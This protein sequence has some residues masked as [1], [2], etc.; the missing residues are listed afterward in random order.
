MN[1]FLDVQINTVGYTFSDKKLTIDYQAITKLLMGEKIYGDAKLALREIVQN[2]IDA[3][4]IR[5]EM[6]QQN[7]KFGDEQ[8]NPTIKVIVNKT[9][10]TVMVKD[11]GYGMDMDIITNYFL[12]VGKSYYTSEAF[13]LKDFNYKPIGNF[14]IGFLACFMLSNEV[15]VRTRHFNSEN[16]ITIS[17]EKESEYI[18]ISEDKNVQFEGTEIELK[19]GS[20]IKP[21]SS[22][23]GK[24]KEFLLKYFLVDG[25]FLEFISV[26]NREILKI[27]NSI[28]LHSNKEAIKEFNLPISDYLIGVNGNVQIKYHEKYVLQFSDLSFPGIP[29][30]Y[31]G[32]SLGFMGDDFCIDKIYCDDF[33]EFIEIPIITEAE[34]EKLKNLYEVFGDYGEAIDLMSA[35]LHKIS[36][37]FDCK[38][39]SDI[40]INNTVVGMYDYI[41]DT[42]FGF[43]DLGEHSQNLESKTKVYSRKINIYKDSTMYL[44]FVPQHEIPNRYNH[45]IVWDTYLRNIFI[46]DYRF[47]PGNIANILKLKQAKINIT[48]KEVIPTVSRNGFDDETTEILNYSISKAIHLSALHH[49]PLD[50]R[51]RRLLQNFT[52]KYY[53]RKTFLDVN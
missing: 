17:L 45:N 49:L 25:Y 31:N 41:I 29:Y 26:E 47:Q 43:E 3:C 30:F 21:F 48:N 51:K 2:G 23:I 33:I 39:Q 6:E 9:E 42:T 16:C 27:K 22:D 19:Y 38:Q 36:I 15:K 7:R 4:K 28:E 18:I 53:S 35:D 32:H 13:L 34:S 12:N 1:P 5:S 44:P 14:G 52:S 37:F 10:N 20:F 24:L 46:K 50:E 11:N 40:D 8:Y